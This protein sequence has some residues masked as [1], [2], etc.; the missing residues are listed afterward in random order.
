MNKLKDNL[1]NNFK[2]IPRYF[3]IVLVLSIVMV[4]LTACGNNTAKN[5]IVSDDTDY[6]PTKTVT[7]SK[8]VIYDGPSIMKSS[9]DVEIQV[10]GQ[11]LFVYD[12]LVNHE[13]MFSFREPTTTAP[14][15]IFD[16]E[17]SV[18]V[19]IT[20]NNE[21]SIESAVVRPLAYGIEPTVSGN[22][23]SFTLDYPANYVVEYD[24]KTEKAINIFTN[25]IEE[26]KPDPDNIPDN[27]VYIGPGVYKADAI[28]VESNET[29]YIAGGAVVYGQIRAENVENVTIK[30]R[31]IISGDIYPRTRAS[32]FT[33]PIE[34]RHSKN[35]TIEDVSFLNPA[36][37]TISAYFVEDL[38]INNIRII[39]ARA[40]GD[41]ISIQSCKDVV[42]KNSFVRSWDDALVVKNYD[43]GNSENITFENMVIWNDLAQSMEIGYETYGDTI[44]DVTFKN[45][46]VLHNF[47]KP[48]MSI[49]NADDA[50]ISN[51]LYKN[52]TVEDAQMVGDNQGFNYDD[53]LID[54]Q[55][56]Y[57]QVW[58]SSGGE[59]GTIDNVTVD[60]VLI[61]NGKDDLVS[62][63]AG[64]DS[65]HK[66]TNVTIK[67]VT[68]KGTKV[69]SAED[70]NLTVNDHTSN[71]SFDFTM[72]K[73]TGAKLILPY[74]LELPADDEAEVEV[75]KNISQ[76]G[77]LVPDF[78]VKDVPP[79]YS[80]AK[81]TGDFTAFATHGTG[82]LEWDDGGGAFESNSHVARNVLDGDTTTSWVGKEW[83]GQP[84]EYAA[85]SIKFDGNRKIGKVR[86]YGNPDSNIYI[87]QNV[88]LFGIRATSRRDVYTKIL[89]SKDYE[90]SPA[91]GNYFN[92]KM[93]PG[94]YKAIQLRFYNREGNAYPDKPFATEIEMYPASL[95]FGKPVTASLHEDVY[96]SSNLTDGNPL[97]YYESKKGKWPAEIV[98][99]MTD[100]YNIQYI[101]LYLPPLMQWVTRTQYISIHVSTDGNNYTEIIPEKGYTFNPQKG[102]IVDIKLEEPV[103]A[104][105]IKFI[106]TGNTALGGYGAQVSEISVYE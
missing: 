13:R 43:R 26:N 3:R 94:E 54:F 58:S 29:I 27:M 48:I 17:G 88:A 38:E 45:I 25:Q 14:V 55:I 53:F 36:G 47:H 99:D 84:N 42:V 8:V 76:E 5:D 49:H 46:T 63:I 11:E 33:I 22:T 62:R 64:Y 1:K 52:I 87:L 56:Q 60:N 6:T 80:G 15:A 77:Y 90:F 83:T 24:G 101:N 9:D 61:L 79:V 93:N 12:T 37:W 39:T 96:D 106:F 102:N 2:I 92:I 40:N 30:G 65:E 75:V 20:V 85:L 104:R 50:D 69:D 4:V 82:F 97:T 71:I 51:I 35:I 16:F 18:D 91:S 32:E 23:I 7:E 86:V 10:E 95:T 44:K 100:K 73:S 105:Y 57:N 19:T 66:V 98:V 103:T 41:G 21:E 59:R 89:N 81:I 28:P 31:G 68:Y 70:L 78:A 74:N 34:F 72:E 67:N